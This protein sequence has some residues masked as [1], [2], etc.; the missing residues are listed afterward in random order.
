M[1]EYEL[2]P[3]N[4]HPN[5]RKLLTEEFYWSPMEETGPFGSDDGSDSFFGFHAWRQENTNESP[6]TY[7][8]ELID[9]W[10]YPTFD[11]HETDVNTIRN[12]NS[13]MLTGTDNA[14][15]AVGFGQFVLE[16]KIDNGLRELT[17]K[18]I[19][20]EL[21]PNLLNAYR[22]DYIETRRQLLQKMMIV[23]DKM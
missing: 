11:M 9:E 7:L 18:A 17:K 1:D 21:T 15:I 23:V 2:S 4:A 10:G 8:E 16:G 12:I 20:R 3:E 22:S 5:A 19:Q 14:I 13:R 6:L